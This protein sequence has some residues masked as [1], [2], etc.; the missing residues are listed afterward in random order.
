MATMPHRR[1]TRRWPAL[2][3]AASKTSWLQYG[4]R[5]EPRPPLQRTVGCGGRT[6]TLR[7]LGS[8]G[9]W[10]WLGGGEVFGCPLV[11]H[12]IRIFFRVWP[13]VDSTLGEHR[14]DLSDHA[15]RREVEMLHDLIAVDRR[16][17]RIEF[18]LLAEHVDSLLEF[19]NPP[20]DRL[21]SPPVP[22]RDVA[23]DQLV[24]IDEE[25]PRVANVAPHRRVVPA[26]LERVGPH[27]EEHE[28]GDILCR[29]LRIVEHFHATPRHPRPYDLM[30]ICLL[31][32]SPS[33]RDRT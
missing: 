7:A 31:Y 18:L 4:V 10:G 1:P 2:S 29:L 32:T 25:I 13:V 9:W 11:E 16:T 33:P 23:A 27:V 30:V 14:H 5:G 17:E 24:E 8:R 6:A 21:L 28:S 12:G 15:S 19:V 3:R 22:R 20:R 26:H